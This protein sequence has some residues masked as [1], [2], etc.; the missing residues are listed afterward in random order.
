MHEFERA[1]EQRSLSYRLNPS[2][3]LYQHSRSSK[4]WVNKRSSKAAGVALAVLE[5]PLKNFKTIEERAPHP[6]GERPH[7][8]KSAL[9]FFNVSSPLLP[10]LGEYS[11]SRASNAWVKYLAH[12]PEHKQTANSEH[13]GNSRKWIHMNH[14][15]RADNHDKK[16][17]VVQRPSVS[18]YEW[19]S[20]ISRSALWNRLLERHQTANS[21]VRRYSFFAAVYRFVTWKM[22]QPCRMTIFIFWSTVH[23][24]AGDSRLKYYIAAIFITVKQWKERQKVAE[25]SLLVIFKWRPQILSDEM[26]SGTAGCRNKRAG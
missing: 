11:Q 25:N 15:R 4:E 14:S 6:Y 17:N 16:Q 26:P 2:I 22:E 10:L 23:L 19:L 12:L 18:V 5:V 8:W 24:N 21:H 3:I 7:Y 13:Q 20:I 1:W 9:Y